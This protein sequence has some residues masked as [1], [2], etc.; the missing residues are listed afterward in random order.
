MGV[1]G[2]GKTTIGMMLAQE[3]GIDYYD[4]DDFHSQSNIS[5]MEKGLALNDN[6]REPWLVN[7]SQELVV[8]KENKGAVLAC[9]ALKESY[10][11]L[12]A[13]S[14]E[15]IHW[16]YLR[17]TYDVIKARVEKRIGHF[18]KTNLLQSQ[19]NTLEEPDYGMSVDIE[20]TPLDVVKIIVS[21]IQK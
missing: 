15:K 5:K 12:L 13:S 19:F 11:Q 21:K 18:M 16:V 10:R 20:N 6:D 14:V 9:S 8:W 7:L 3:L 1:S 4:A 17:G 2:C